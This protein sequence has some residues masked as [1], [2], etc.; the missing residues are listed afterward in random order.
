[1]L[2]VNDG[3]NEPTNQPIESSETCLLVGG[4]FNGQGLGFDEMDTD[5]E[6][7]RENVYSYGG[8]RD[9]IANL[10]T[11]RGGLQSTRTTIYMHCIAL[12]SGIACNRGNG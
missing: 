3:T 11:E 9:A 8:A 12:Q 7:R 6:A 2:H 5:Q 1:M 4:I 10:P